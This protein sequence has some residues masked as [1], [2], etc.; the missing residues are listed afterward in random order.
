MARNLTFQYVFESSL[1]WSEMREHLTMERIHL[2]RT[3]Y[4]AVKHHDDRISFHLYQQVDTDFSNTFSLTLH[5]SETR[6]YPVGTGNEMEGCVTLLNPVVAVWFLVLSGLTLFHVLRE[7]LTTVQRY[8]MG[9][10]PVLKARILENIIPILQNMQNSWIFFSMYFVLWALMA[11]T[12]GREG[13][14]HH[15]V[16]KAIEPLLKGKLRKTRKF[17][18]P[19]PHPSSGA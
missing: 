15:T 9:Y 17:S 3:A 4:I 2:R 12:A 1:T 13:E 11:W 10:D 6:R 7:A 14:A 8:G 19:V 16:R 18:A 5:P